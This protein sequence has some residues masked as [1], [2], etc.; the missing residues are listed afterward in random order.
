[1]Y[2]NKFKMDIMYGKNLLIFKMDIMY[3]NKFN[4]ISDRYYVC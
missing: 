4:D 2:D 3:D 1:M